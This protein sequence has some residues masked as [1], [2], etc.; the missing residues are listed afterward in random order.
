MPAITDPYLTHSHTIGV[1]GRGEH[2]VSLRTRLRAAMHRPEL[3]RALAEGADPGSGEELAVRAS[4]LTSERNRRSVA[5]ALRR[6][7]DEAHRPPLGRHKVL[8]R[9]GEVIDA[10]PAIR[11]LIDRLGG[12]QPTRVEGMAMIEMILTNADN[13]PLYHPRPRRSLRDEITAATDA[14]GSDVS[15]SHEFP[16]GV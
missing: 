4:R 1:A 8:I 11:A 7:I 3:T 13:S 9:R 6:A 10:E 16:V 15:A 12:P 2:D 14:M 5:R